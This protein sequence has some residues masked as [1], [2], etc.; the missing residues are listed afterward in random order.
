M[1]SITL[2]I[3][4]LSI[5]MFQLS[6][7]KDSVAQ[8]NSTGNYLQDGKLLSL[9][10]DGSGF[11]IENYDSSNAKNISLTLPQNYALYDANPVISPDHKTI[12]FEVANSKDLGKITA[13]YT[14][15]CSID[16]S[17]LKKV[18]DNGGWHVAF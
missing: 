9:N 8:V 2:F 1:G 17:D 6:C 18:D 7:K 11:T 10:S 16:G 4:S 5:I 3:F 12:F 15:S 13:V 14:Y